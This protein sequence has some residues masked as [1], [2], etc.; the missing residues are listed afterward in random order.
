MNIFLAIDKTL[1]EAAGNV[2]QERLA[3]IL[4]Y[5]DVL[6]KNYD[7]QMDELQQKSDKMKEDIAKNPNITKKE[8]GMMPS[9]LGWGAIIGGVVLGIV[10]GVVTGGGLLIG[11][12]IAAMSA[13]V[14]AGIGTAISP[15]K[16]DHDEKGNTG[17]L[18]KIWDN[19]RALQSVTES[20]IKYTK[21]ID[22]DN[23]DCIIQEQKASGTQG[24][25]DNALK[26]KYGSAQ[27]TQTASQS[28]FTQALSWFGN[29]TVRA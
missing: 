5:T 4:S 6:R 14:I 3:T 28:M 7:E 10:L 29:L 18:K 25:I 12:G 17:A 9:K 16:E 13:A 24:D 2:S 26:I 11:L 22:S 19:A 20:D 27:D 23:S 1:Q 15:P 8:R 21:R